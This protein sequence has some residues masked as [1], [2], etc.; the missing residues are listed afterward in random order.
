M[1]LPGHGP[2]ARAEEAKRPP[3]GKILEIIA[4][5]P[6]VDGVGF[7]AGGHAL[8]RA[9]ARRPEAFRRLAVLGV[10]DPGPPRHEPGALADLLDSGAPSSDP[11]VEL[12]RRL[13]TSA[14]NDLPAASAFLRAGHP[15]VDAATIRRVR[16][17]TLVIIGAA[18]PA[19]PAD[20]LAEALPEAQLLVLP[21]VD[22]FATPGD[23]RTMMA[24]LEF[25]AG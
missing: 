2:D 9:A 22:H 6:A 10:G 13:V 23:P 4:D 15:P 18:D 11:E 5:L 1:D 14:G 8:L 25:L 7:S 3:S 24:V 20:R 19:G 12:F 21:G 16:A 17:P